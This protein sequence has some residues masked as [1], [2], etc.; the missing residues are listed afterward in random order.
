MLREEQKA[1]ENL[2]RALALAPSS[3]EVRFNAA[4]VANQL[5]NDAAAITWLQKALESGV[6]LDLINNIANFDNLRSSKP[7]EELLRAKNPSGTNKR[8]Q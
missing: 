4:L 1:S 7:F 5:G 3:P 8:P 6:P 2:N